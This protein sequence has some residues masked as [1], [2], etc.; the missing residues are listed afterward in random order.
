MAQI[1]RGLIAVCW[2]VAT[3]SATSTTPTSRMTR[4]F[5]FQCSM[6]TGKPT[7]ETNRWGQR[8]MSKINNRRTVIT[9]DGICTAL[10]DIDNVDYERFMFNKGYDAVPKNDVDAVTKQ[11]LIDHPEKFRPYTCARSSD[12]E[13]SY[14]EFANGHIDY[15]H[16]TW[17]DNEHT[18]W[19][20]LLIDEFIGW[21]LEYMEKHYPK[22]YKKLLVNSGSPPTNVTDDDTKK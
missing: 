19:E 20:F 7:S 9:I 21:D 5:T 6:M 1:I 3:A 22:L 2:L 14:K 4:I 17:S 18:N 15:E 16:G 8:E 11:D 10:I 13:V 12:F